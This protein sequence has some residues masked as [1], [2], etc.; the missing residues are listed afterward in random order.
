MKRSSN[1][2]QILILRENTC[3]GW[4]SSDSEPEAGNDIGANNGGQD[5][6]FE[7]FELFKMAA[8]MTSQYAN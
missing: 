7:L 2:T 3:H 8:M 1:S 5:D 4:P 6:D